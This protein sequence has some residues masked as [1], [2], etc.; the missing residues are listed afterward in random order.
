MQNKEV[1]VIACIENGDFRIFKFVDCETNIKQEIEKANNFYKNFPE[2]NRRYVCISY[3][4]YLKLQ[5]DY[6]MK[7]CEA[8]TEEKY[9]EM[10]EVLPPIYISR[11]YEIPGYTV[12]NAFMVSEPLTYTYYNGYIKYRNRKGEIKYASKVISRGDRSTYWTTEDLDKLEG[13]LWT[14]LLKKFKK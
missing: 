11:A 13:N 1:K 5:A 4:K 14:K 7:S 6:Y 3:D 9:W 2:F 12:L 10:L 8:V